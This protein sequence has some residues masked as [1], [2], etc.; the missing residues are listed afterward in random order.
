VGSDYY[1]RYEHDLND[2]Y[3]TPYTTTK[4]YFRPLGVEFHQLSPDI[5]QQKGLICVDCHVSK[6]LMTDGQSK[7]HCVDCH[8]KSQIRITSTGLNISHNI[9]DN[10]YNLLSAGDK[11]QHLIP[12]MQHPAHEKYNKQVNCQV[13]HAQWSFNDKGTH[14]LRNDLDEYDDFSKLTVQGSFEVENIIKNN[15]D[16][17]KDEMPHS[18]SDKITGEKRIGLWYKGFEIRRWEHVT[19]GRDK[20]GRLQVMRPVLDLYLSWVDNEEKVH[21]DSIRANAPDN[22]L[23][24]YVPHTTGKAGLFYEDR[25]KNFLNS[26]KE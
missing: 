20:S 1:G 24:P 5:H 22:G 15:L 19:I 8:A 25:I 4:D 12:L 23:V 7:I 13:C 14:L 17:D 6:E 2:E 26:E 18:M 16:F 10:T 3:R 11:K 21:F 9:E